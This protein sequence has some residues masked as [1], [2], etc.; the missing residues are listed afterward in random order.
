LVGGEESDE[1]NLA[2]IWDVDDCFVAGY[3]LQS[4]VEHFSSFGLGIVEDYTSVVVVTRT[5][6]PNSE[7]WTVL[8]ANSEREVITYEALSVD[9]RTLILTPS[10]V[11]TVTC[12]GDRAFAF[13]FSSWCC[14]IL[15]GC[16]V[17][18]FGEEREM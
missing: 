9:A 16:A 10:L 18:M 2:L 14:G 1:I 5:V 7:Y 8:S 12:P 13:A 17:W 3:D 11:I 6:Y 4:S 15:G